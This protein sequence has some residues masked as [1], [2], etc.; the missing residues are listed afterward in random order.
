MYVTFQLTKLSLYLTQGGLFLSML[1]LRVSLTVKNK[2]K[3][4]DETPPQE[5]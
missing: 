1:L 3:K 2:C 4:D 5:S